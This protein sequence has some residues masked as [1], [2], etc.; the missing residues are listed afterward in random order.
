MCGHVFTDNSEVDVGTGRFQFT[1]HNRV[2]DH[3]IL[4]EGSLAVF[5]DPNRMATVEEVNK[6]AETVAAALNAKTSELI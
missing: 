3:S 5:E 2:N 4:V 6:I 1:L